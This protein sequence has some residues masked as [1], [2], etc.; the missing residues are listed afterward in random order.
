[1]KQSELVSRELLKNRCFVVMANE[2]VS[3]LLEL[4]C[5]SKCGPYCKSSKANEN[6]KKAPLDEQKTLKIN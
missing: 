1:M 3:I 4:N 2:N 6:S 5:C